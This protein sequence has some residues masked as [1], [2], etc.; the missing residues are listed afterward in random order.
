MI[1]G[2]VVGLAPG[3]SVYRILIAE[4]QHENQLLLSRLMTSIGLEVIVAGNGEECVK[5]FQEWHPALIWM[6]R[7]MPVMDGVEAT[8]RIRLLP[9]GKKVRIVAV[10]ASAFKEQQQEMFDVGMDDFIR[11]PYRFDEIYD[12][13]ARQLGIK[14]TYNSD[15]Q[16]EPAPPATLTPAAVAVIPGALRKELKDALESLDEDLIKS[17]IGHV[18]E[19]DPELGRT[20]FHHAEYFDY[21][22]ILNALDQTSK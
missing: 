11:K 19:I 1:H 2:E 14:Y 16:D 6:D 20:L 5:R 21:P 18:S 12:C 15:T 9:E 22:A 10:T 8:R 7:R 17:T 13:L 3:Q 4:D